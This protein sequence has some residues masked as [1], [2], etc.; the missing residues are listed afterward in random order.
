VDTVARLNE[1]DEMGGYALQGVPLSSLDYIPARHL[2]ILKKY[3]ITTVYDLLYEFPTRYE[4]FIPTSIQNA[5]LDENIVLEGNIASKVNV[6]YLRNRLT[7][8]TFYVEVEGQAVRCTLFNRQFL[9]SKLRYGVLVRISGKFNQNFHSF[10][11]ANIILCD[12]ISRE[13]VPVYR[14]KTISESKY[15]DMME[16]VYHQFKNQIEEELPEELNEK[17]NLISQAEAIRLLHFPSSFS[18]I[19]KAEEKMKH[20][21]IFKHQLS[22]KYIQEMRHREPNGN[23]ILYDEKIIDDFIS[24]LPYELTADQKTTIDE[25]LQNMSEPY[26]MN[27]LLQGEVGSGKTTVAAIVMLAAVSGGYQAAL[28]CPTEILAY[29]HFDTL[30][31][32]Y[33]DYDMVN[34]A[35]LTSSISAKDR[36]VILEDLASGKINILIGTHA[37]FQKDVVYQNLG[38]VIADEEHRF[39]VR[40]RVSIRNK[41]KDVD[42]LKMS[43]TPIP[44]SLAITAYGDNEISV[45]KTMPKGRKDVVTKFVE[46]H[47]KRLVVEHMKEEIENGHQIYVVTP[48]I[49]ESEAIDTANATKIY[50]NMKDYFKGIAEV[51]LLHGKVKSEEREQVMERFINKEIQILVA[52]SVIEVGVNVPNATTIV[53]LGAER[54]GVAQLH[55]LRGRVMRSDAVPYCFLISDFASESAIERLKMVEENSDG[56]VLAEY[57]LKVRGPGEFFGEKQSGAMNFKY[58]DLKEDTHLF[59]QLDN[60]AYQLIKNPAFETDPKYTHL[61]E[62]VRKINQRVKVELD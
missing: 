3:D 57:D 55:Q 15:L 17:Y 25:I 42:Y 18:E 22:L 54:F 36:K 9:K 7:T 21:E 49:N 34:V 27:R 20:V 56:F 48:L 10:T 37:I 2:N 53:I 12:E 46:D 47:E 52:T 1:Q 58:C 60:D 32:A 5:V 24:K 59:E 31:K 62:Y 38:I 26:Q 30:K 50:E 44:R 41:G 39:G 8:L 4:N 43:A 28:L 13:L 11:V 14:A 40:Q 45:I 23:V 33:R 61:Y 6:N 16:K 51:G 19:E 35:V 29:Q